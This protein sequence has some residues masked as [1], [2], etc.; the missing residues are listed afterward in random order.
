MINTHK[1]VGLNEALD[2]RQNIADDEIDLAEL[3]RIL[4]AG[5]WI[6]ISVTLAFAV[7]TAGI[8][9]ML[10]NQYKAS[11]IL[12]AA[13]KEGGG[14]L[15][16]LAAQYG[17]L[18]AMAGIN[19]GKDPGKLDQAVALLKSWS[20]VDSFISKYPI[21]PEIM[22]VEKWDKKTDQLI[23]DLEEYNPGTNAWVVGKSPDEPG[24]P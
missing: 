18:A 5:K 4:W 21:K 6:I 11:V 13:Q 2:Q 23:F 17:G 9:L 1:T 7:V 12:A 15:G 16:G 3:F 19:I 24:E 20:F 10:P 14:G 8:T 22:A